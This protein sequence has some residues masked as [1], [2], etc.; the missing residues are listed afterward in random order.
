MADYHVGAGEI[1]GEIYAGVLAKDGKTWRNRSFVTDEAICAVRDHLII[2]MERSNTRT[3]TPMMQITGLISIDTDSDGDLN[4]TIEKA[5]NE[6]VLNYA[7]LSQDTTYM[8]EQIE[9][10]EVS[11][12]QYEIKFYPTQ[13]VSGWY[14]IKLS[15]D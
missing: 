9:T 12:Y 7:H 6:F 10:K 8:V 4:I 5:P 14:D 1:T 2:Q 11:K 15:D 3:D 13:L